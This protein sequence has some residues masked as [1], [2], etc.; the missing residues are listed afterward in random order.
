MHCIALLL[1]CL[2]SKVG[3][4]GGQLLHLVLCNSMQVPKR[5]LAASF[6]AFAAMHCCSLQKQLEPY[7]SAKPGA[8][9][10]ITQVQL[11]SGRPVTLRP[12]D[13]TTVQ[14]DTHV[15]LSDALQ[16]LQRWTSGSPHG[17]ECCVQLPEQPE[18]DAGTGTSAVDRLAI[19]AETNG[20][21]GAASEDSANTNKQKSSSSSGSSTAGLQ[22][23]V[24]SAGPHAI[25]PAGDDAI[26]DSAA[27][28][29]DA[30]VGRTV[31]SKEAPLQP[32][33]AAE[34]PVC[35]NSSNSSSSTSRLAADA[36]LH[37]AGLFSAGGCL[38]VP[39]SCHR[40]C[41]VQDAAGCVIGV[42][43]CLQAAVPGA[44]GGLADVLS[45][46]K[47]SLSA[48]GGMDRWGGAEG[49]NALHLIVSLHSLC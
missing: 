40:V 4:H 13:R 32:E 36:L 44:A 42:T 15:T 26:S 34:G 29:H 43:Y 37:A 19:G 16:H 30:A 3:S 11:D 45:G 7:L 22:N 28:S 8:A 39:G 47:A 27:A 20:D 5:M 2:F 21:A 10:L 41:A 6:V 12:S 31:A 49:T 35:D 48:E 38:G 25:A 23:S 1:S 9:P 18:G 33:C 14:L 17:R 24:A 46:M